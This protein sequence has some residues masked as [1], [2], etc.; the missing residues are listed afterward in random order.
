[1]NMMFG[2]IALSLCEFHFDDEDVDALVGGMMSL[3]EPLIV[4]VLGLIVGTIVIALFLPLVKLIDQRGAQ[5]SG[6]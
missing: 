3:M 1:M 4:I 2:F 5:A 6:G